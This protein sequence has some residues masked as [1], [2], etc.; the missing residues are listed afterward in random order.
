[1]RVVK[2]S[3]RISSANNPSGQP[4]WIRRAGKPRRQTPSVNL[5]D[6]LADCLADNLVDNLLVDN[7]TDNLAEL[8][9]HS[10]P[11]HL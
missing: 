8:S 1:M 10:R 2:T 6:S 7:L 4:V 5:A 11:S 9:R 3:N